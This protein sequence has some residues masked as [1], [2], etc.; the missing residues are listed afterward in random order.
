[1][2]IDFSQLKTK[3]ERKTEADKAAIE[4]VTNKRASEYKSLT[5]PQVLEILLKRYKDDVDL[6]P[7]WAERERIQSENPYP[8]GGI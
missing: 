6:A 2:N 4:A 1:M 7:I 8:E 3:E 5:D